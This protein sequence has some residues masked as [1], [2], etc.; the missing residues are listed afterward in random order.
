M[1]STLIVFAALAVAAPAAAETVNPMVAPPA[2][3]VDSARLVEDL[4]VLSADDMAGRAPGTPGG[5]KARAYVVRRFAE[6]GLEPVEAPFAFTTKDG[7]RKTG[8][9]VWAVVRGTGRADKWIVVTAHYDHL[10]VKDG[11]VHNGADDNASGTAA[12][13]ALAERFRAERPNHSILFVALDAEE[14]GSRGARALVAAPPAPKDAIL[15]NVNL[16]MVARADRGEL[17]AAGAYHYPDLKPVLDFAATG[18]PLRLRQGHDRPELGDG[19]WTEQS[20]H[21][22]FHAAG[23]PFVYFGVEDHA[24]YHR[25]SDDFDKVDPQAYV[26][27]VRTIAAAVRALD[28]RPDVLDRARGVAR[29]EPAAPAPAIRPDRL[30]FAHGL[31]IGV[32]ATF[33][34]MTLVLLLARRQW[35]RKG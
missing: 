11:Q 31:A 23:I 16:D 3:Q 4:R 28:A 14:G 1:K 17:Y 24:D 6:L 20:D 33:A 5:A 19:D 26:R 12:L 30:G 21:S 2:P 13:L 32:A 22:A 10:G 35:R 18:T 29:A 34:L 25:P 9:N 27:S 8:V 15:L 7:A